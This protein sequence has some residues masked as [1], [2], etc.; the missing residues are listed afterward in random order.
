MGLL[1]SIFG[2]GGETEIEGDGSDV[3]EQIAETGVNAAID[4]MYAMCANNG[5]ATL[6]ESVESDF[7]DQVDQ[8]ADGEFEEIESNHPEA[9]GE[10]TDVGNAI[11]KQAADIC[12]AI[13]E[14]SD[15][16][17]L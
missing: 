16:L 4:V 10:I 17:N 11:C 15:L 3:R 1:D 14:I 9:V 2:G 6:I 12:D 13:K 8:I 7:S 5:Q